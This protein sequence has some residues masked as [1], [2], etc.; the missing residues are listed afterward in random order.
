MKCVLYDDAE[1]FGHRVEDF[2]ATREIENNLILGVWG[3]LLGRAEIGAVM[4]AVED[5]GRIRLAALMTP[6]YRLIVSK[7]DR[8]AI[9][10]LIDG[11]GR[12]GI[13]LPGV[14]GVVDMSEAFAGEWHA[15]T[16]QTIAPATEMTLYALEKVVMPAPVTGEF[17]QADES[18]FDRVAEWV[19]DFG[20]E[21]SLPEHSRRQEVAEEKMTR[22]AVY[23]WDVDG[24]PVSM[25][26]F[27]AATGK[28][29]RVNLVYTPPAARRKGYASACV[30][31]MSRHLLESG[32]KWCAIFAD[33]SNPTSNSIYR[34]MGYEEAATYREYDFAPA[35]AER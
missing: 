29:V 34:R 7:G 28:G 1:T 11:I 24:A 31:H 12:D 23:F 27:S 22:R 10:C 35:E 26:S 2:L 9:R 5:D 30:A 4:L 32:R 20:K 17:R 16:G 8:E 14:V 3:G 19:G 6:P 13:E 21:L 33:V 18:D 15:M 25:A